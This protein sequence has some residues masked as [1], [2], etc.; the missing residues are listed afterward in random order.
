MKSHIPTDLPERLT[1]AVISSPAIT[2]VWKLVYI[3]RSRIPP[4]KGSLVLPPLMLV[5][6]QEMLGRPSVLPFLGVL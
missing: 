1:V 4:T 2:N 3:V 6:R 5:Q